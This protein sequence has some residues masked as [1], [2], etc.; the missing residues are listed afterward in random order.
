MKPD[1]VEQLCRQLATDNADLSALLPEGIQGEIGH[2]NVFDLA[3]LTPVP[4]KPSIPFNC[5]TY[6][7]ISLLRGRSRAE[8]LDK[9]VEMEPNTLIFSMPNV[10]FY[11]LAQDENLLGQFC[12]FTADFLQP[13]NS[14]VVLENMPVFRRTSFPVFQL[15][16]NETTAVQGIFEKMQAELRSDYLYKYDLLRAYA[17]ELIHFGQKLQPAAALHPAH[18]ASARMTSQFVELLERQF[19]LESP[20]QQIRFHTAND[21]AD[22]LAVHVNHLNKVLKVTTGLTTTE[23]IA[24]RLTQEARILLRQTHWTIAQVAFSLGFADVA[25]FSKF[26]KRQTALSPGAFRETSVVEKV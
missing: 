17:L 12:V 25:H 8:Y 26:F 5:R 16:D 15:S 21:Y 7:K 9:T 20:Q 10:P 1:S 18:N 13:G 19:P 22:H 24:G 2:F 3:D 6:Y 14:G 4:Q 23:L 11:W